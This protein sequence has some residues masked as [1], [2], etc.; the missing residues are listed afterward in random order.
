MGLSMYLRQNESEDESSLIYWR[1][2]NTIHGWFIRNV[3]GGS[4]NCKTHRVTREK[5]YELRDFCEEILVGKRTVDSL[6]SYVFETESWKLQC[7]K[8]TVDEI[9]KLPDG[10]V[11]YYTATW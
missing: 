1:N 3:Q 11:F 10:T 6:I 4:D 8:F 5:L 2:A 9:N 7:M